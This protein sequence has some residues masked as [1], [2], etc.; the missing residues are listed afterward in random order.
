MAVRK[1]QEE[2]ERWAWY[3][4]MGTQMYENKYGRLTVGGDTIAETCAK[5]ADDL[6]DV[7]IY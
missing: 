4:F 1:G 6:N 3:C 7:Y 5:V 2:D